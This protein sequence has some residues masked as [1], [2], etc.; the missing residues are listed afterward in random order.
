MPRFEH[1]FS[2]GFDLAKEIMT[3]L[4][5]TDGICPVSVSTEFD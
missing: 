5:S 1:D 2:P 3:K 4:E